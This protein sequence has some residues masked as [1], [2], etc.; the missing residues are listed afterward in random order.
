MGGDGRGGTVRQDTVHR[1]KGCP[2]RTHHPSKTVVAWLKRVLFLLFILS[3]SFQWPCSSVSS[4]ASPSPPHAS[5]PGSCKCKRT[6]GTAVL[7]LP[8]PTVNGGLTRNSDDVSLPHNLSVTD[9][10]LHVLPRIIGAIVASIEGPC[11]CHFSPRAQKISDM[12]EGRP[13]WNRAALYM[14]CAATKKKRENAD[15]GG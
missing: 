8:A 11:L 14:G 3:S 15:S 12:I 13:K 5:L 1:G 2:Q 9:S 6:D 7:L 10:S 4:P